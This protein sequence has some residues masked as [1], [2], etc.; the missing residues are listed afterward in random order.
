M[1]DLFDLPGAEIVVEAIQRVHLAQGGIAVAQ[2][3]RGPFPGAQPLDQLTGP[4]GRLPQDGN[5]D[6]AKWRPPQ[7]RGWRPAWLAGLPGLPNCLR[8]SVTAQTRQ[9][10]AMTL[11]TVPPDAVDS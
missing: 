8:T 10:D 2:P 1:K 5:N 7:P 3:G 4:H 6:S 9:A 11:H